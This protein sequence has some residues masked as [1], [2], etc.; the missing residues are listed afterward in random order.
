MSWEA[1]IG[2]QSAPVCPVQTGQAAGNIYPPPVPHPSEHDLRACADHIH[3]IGPV[4]ARRDGGVLIV[5]PPIVDHETDLVHRRPDQRSHIAILRAAG[6]ARIA[7]VQP[8]IADIDLPGADTARTDRV[9]DLDPLEHAALIGARVV[10]Q[11]PARLDRAAKEGRVGRASAADR[12]PEGFTG[13]M[14]P[15]GDDR[16]LRAITGFARRPGERSRIDEAGIGRM[17]QR[18]L[19]IA[20][21]GDRIA[22]IAPM[23]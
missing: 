7:Q 17:N 8:V 18:P 5:H 16:G 19:A 15:P 6:D 11:E 10:R 12:L 14:E 9:L 20:D 22:Q 4:G 3:A 21:A 13:R 23:P 1:V 2:F